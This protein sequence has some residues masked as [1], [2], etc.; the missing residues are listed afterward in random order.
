MNTE[1]IIGHQRQIKNLEFLLKSENIPQTILFTGIGGI[2]KSLI[3]KRFINALFCKSENPPCLA[4]SVCRQFAGEAFPDFVEISPNEKGIIPIGSENNHERGTVRWLI[5]RSSSKSISGRYGVIIDGVD[6]ITEEGQN[7][8]LKTIEEP[9]SGSCFLLICSN[10]NNLLSTILSRC[11]EVR[12]L[13]LSEAELREILTKKD[14]P[15]RELDLFIKLSGGSIEIVDI[16]SDRENFDEIIEICKIISDYLKENGIIESG[17]IAVKN[18]KTEL[19]L[20]IIINI[21]RLN[22]ISLLKNETVIHSEIENIFLNS[23][24]DVSDLLKILLYLKGNGLHNINIKYAIKGMLYNSEIRKN[25]SL[26]YNFSNYI[27]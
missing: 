16:L 9:G 22:F 12:F 8:L 23:A 18:I 27:R 15:V 11:L 21:Y 14:I 6:R 7:A 19:L 5:Q 10:R 25:N 17:R 2:G 1:G 24:D 3:A 26:S 4:C 13:P 20:D